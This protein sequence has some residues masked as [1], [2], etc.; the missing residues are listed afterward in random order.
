MISINDRNSITRLPRLR[1][2]QATVEE[3]KRQDPDTSIT[4]FYVRQLCMSGA[5]F[6]LKNGPKYLINLDLLFAYLSDCAA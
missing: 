1:T 4:E 5:P 6:V 3:C 2:I